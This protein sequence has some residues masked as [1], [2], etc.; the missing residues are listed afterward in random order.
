[1]TPRGAVPL[2]SPVRH[3]VGCVRY[4]IPWTNRFFEAGLADIKNS[5]GA[6]NDGVGTVSP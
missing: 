6:E 2:Y 5:L 4:P 3:T 1:M